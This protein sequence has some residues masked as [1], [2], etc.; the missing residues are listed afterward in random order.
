MAAVYM[1]QTRVVPLQNVAYD[2]SP[3]INYLLT[4]KCP[5]TPESTLSR[6]NP[7]LETVCWAKGGERRGLEERGATRAPHLW[8]TS[9]GHPGTQM[10]CNCGRD[11]RIDPAWRESKEGRRSRGLAG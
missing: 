1:G 6:P 8:P 11:R 10:L 2:M 9:T 4:V 7:L 5:Q 3:R